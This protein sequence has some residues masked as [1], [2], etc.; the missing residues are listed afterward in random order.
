V[1]VLHHLENPLAGWKILCRI[2]KRG[3][4]MRIGLYSELGRRAIA[5]AQSAI[6]R[7]GSGADYQGMLR[8]RRESKTLLA[9]NIL[10][11]LAS[12]ADYYYL[13]MYRDLLFPA[14]EHRF[15]ARQIKDILSELG[16][17]FMGF[18]LAPDVM[19]RYRRRF[20][21]DASQS[22]LDK[23]HEFEQANP[24]TFDGMYIFWCREG[25]GETPS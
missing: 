13:S 6:R 24:A 23:W 1:G 4:L 8:F 15:S 14:K 3:G 19:A 21:D 22:N 17:V 18:Y 5:A 25:D 11:D 9:P 2:L 12:R 16:L 20:P 7:E 10:E